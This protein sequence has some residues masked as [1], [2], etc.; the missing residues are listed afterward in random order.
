M[1][2]QRPAPFDQACEGLARCIAATGVL[3][4]RRQIHMPRQMVGT[5][6]SF[7]DGTRARVYRETVTSRS[8]SVPC[9]LVVRFRL[10]WVRGWGHAAFRWESLLNTPL[11]V[12]FPGFVSKL[13]LTADE[14]GNYRGLYEW[15][16]EALAEHYARCLWWVLA[17]VSTPGSIRYQVVTG[18]TRRAM[19]DRVG[20]AG[21]AG[22]DGDAWWLVS[23]AG[24]PA[25]E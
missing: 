14:R 18:T 8:H 9:L 10:R 1:S 24:V 23:G 7:A 25:G 11:F 4:W 6:I 17:L 2:E 12:G 20:G 19:L 5:W 15:D 3:L 21:D 13:W 16:G 22:A